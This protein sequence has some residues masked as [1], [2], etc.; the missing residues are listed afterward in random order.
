MNIFLETNKYHYENQFGF[1]K[2]HSINHVLITI[3]EQIRH[4][5]DGNHYVCG[6]FHG[7]QK[8]FDTVNLDILLSKLH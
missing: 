6:V 8:A 7:F 1:K 3:T 2:Q 5:F 4:T